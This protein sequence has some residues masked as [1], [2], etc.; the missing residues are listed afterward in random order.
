METNAEH[1]HDIQ[2]YIEIAKGSNQKY[3]FNKNTHSLELDRILPEPHVYPY[4][5]GFI[6]N[7]VAEDGDELDVLIIS[8]REIL[9]ETTLSA[10]IVGALLMEDEKGN[11]PKILA[12][13]PTEPDFGNVHNL[14]D[15][16]SSQLESIQTFFAN[17]KLN[18]HPERWSI[19]HGFIS[20]KG[21]LQIYKDSVGKR[22]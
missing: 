2:V 1:E 21:A 8:D 10:R 19:V 20:K 4:A 5:Y 9:P 14:S 18:N 13:L 12:V 7:T 16:S 15:I 3:E 22:D 11:D 6:P 17:Y